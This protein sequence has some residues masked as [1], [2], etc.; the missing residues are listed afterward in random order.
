MAGVKM[1]RENSKGC[2]VSG[3]KLRNETNKDN[4]KTKLFIQFCYYGGVRDETSIEIMK[5][6][7]F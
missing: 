1:K 4:I 5:N 7:N 2:V 3:K 6:T